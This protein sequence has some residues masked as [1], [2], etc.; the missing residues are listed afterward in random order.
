MLPI[1]RCRKFRRNRRIKETVMNR[2]NHRG[3]S[4]VEMKPGALDATLGQLVAERP[5]RSRIFE[6]YGIDYCCGGGKALAEA[7]AAKHI[8]P[9]EVLAGLLSLEA[10]FEEDN[11]I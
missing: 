9:D 4:E 11:E 10:E 7:C 8:D 6:R 2:M 5:R 3:G 1:H